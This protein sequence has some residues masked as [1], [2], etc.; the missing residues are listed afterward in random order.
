MSSLSMPSETGTNTSIL[1]WMAQQFHAR[2][3]FILLMIW[4]L[5]TKLALWHHPHISTAMYDPP[6]HMMAK[7]FLLAFTLLQLLSSVNR[8][9]H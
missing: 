2:P 3:F 1:T 6:L 5:F 8:E 4:Y 9:I 7:L